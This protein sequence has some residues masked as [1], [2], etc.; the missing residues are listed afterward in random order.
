[1]RSVEGLPVETVVLP[2]N[3]WLVPEA[4]LSDHAPFWDA[5]YP[6]LLVT[7]TAFLRNPHYHQ[8]TDTLDTLDLA[9]VERV[10]QGLVELI[11]TVAA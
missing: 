2:A 10:C 11:T 1:M 6:A 5:G 8:P 4:R 7:D 3:G 9:F